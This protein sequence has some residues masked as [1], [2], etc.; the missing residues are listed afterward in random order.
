MQ[1]LQLARSLARDHGAKLIVL[2]VALPAI[3]SS[4]F[5]ANDADQIADLPRQLAAL[6]ST[7]DDVSAEYQV[8][9][10]QPGPAITE[11][12]EKVGANL[13]VMGTTGRSDLPW[14]VMGSVAEYVTRNATCPVLTVKVGTTNR[15]LEVDADS[16]DAS[17]PVGPET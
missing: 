14:M 5:D 3:P 8:V 13:I 10:G 6:T 15:R 11:C 12:A 9:E 17:S 4:E 2:G 1:S 16:T 7:I